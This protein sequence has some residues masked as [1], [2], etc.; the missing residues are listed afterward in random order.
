MVD[1]EKW[2]KE[3]EKLSD[4][5]LIDELARPTGDWRQDVLRE[6]MIRLLKLHFK[7]KPKDSKEDKAKIK[8]GLTTQGRIE[9]PE[10]T[11]EKEET[12]Q[13]LM[14]QKGFEPKA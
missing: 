5:E 8:K 10:Q 1:K 3:I 9:K 2:R 14:K 11:F 13:F 12:K 7:A 6:F 4:D